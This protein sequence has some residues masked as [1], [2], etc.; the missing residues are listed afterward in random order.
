M[1]IGYGDHEGIRP[2]E[3]GIGRVGPVSVDRINGCESV[4]GNRGDR[5]VGSVGQTIRISRVEITRCGSVL[6]DGCL[7]VSS[8]DG[9]IIHGVDDQVDGDG[10]I[11]F[12]I[13]DLNGKGIR[14]VII[15]IGLVGQG[16]A[17][18][19]GPCCG[20]GGSFGCKSSLGS[21][22]SRVSS[23]DSLGCKSSLGSLGSRVRG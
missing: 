16:G 14:S 3:V 12:P 23:S 8:Y 13:T 7:G 18:G 15:C 10:M 22:G 11:V 21:P 19:C 4:C 6:G 20:S 5:K 9:G 2:K 1:V 17:Y